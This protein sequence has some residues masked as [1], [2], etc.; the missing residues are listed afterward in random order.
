MPHHYDQVVDKRMK[1]LIKHYCQ[2]Q[3][4]WDWDVVV[5]DVS[6]YSEVLALFLL[7]S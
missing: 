5:D 3:L 6:D 2:R 7:Q 4:I 1:C